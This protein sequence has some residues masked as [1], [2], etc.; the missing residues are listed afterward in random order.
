MTR[1]LSVHQSRVLASLLALEREHKWYWW[2][3]YAIGHV[4][5]AGGYHV[6]IQPRTMTIL[7]AEGLVMTERSSW[8]EGVKALIRCN[9][10]CCDWGLTAA[11]RKVARSINVAWSEESTKR[12]RD[13]KFYSNACRTHF[14]DDDEPPPGFDS[15]DDDG[16]S[17][18]PNAPR[19]DLCHT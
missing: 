6:T 11:G 10:A 19:G 17:P 7:K 4:V 2:P 13:A 8:P 16:D 3:R 15:D 12:L 5:D 9:C 14:R 1:K 18:S